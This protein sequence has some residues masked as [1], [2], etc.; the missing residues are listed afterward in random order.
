M[1]KALAKGI[2]FVSYAHADRARVEPLVTALKKRFNIFW[3]A[4]SPECLIGGG[5]HN[6]RAFNKLSTKSSYGLRTA[7]VIKAP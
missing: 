3:G 6:T 4:E 2:V 7:P 1:A 5:F